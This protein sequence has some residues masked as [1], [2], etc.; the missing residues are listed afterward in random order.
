MLWLI[1]NTS[2]SLFGTTAYGEALIA[3]V[4]GALILK[5]SVTWLT[6]AGGAII[7]LSIFLTF[8]A[9][10]PSSEADQVASPK[11]EQ[12]EIRDRSAT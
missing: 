12:P 5:E 8:R 6:L 10:R 7:L 11:L 9:E 4:L 3:V 1:K 2:P